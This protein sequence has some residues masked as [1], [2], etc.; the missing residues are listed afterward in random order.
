MT[1]EVTT[2]ALTISGS[3]LVLVTGQLIVRFVIDPIHDQKRHLGEIANAL[4]FY[5]NLYSNPPEP[6]QGREEPSPIDDD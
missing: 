3:V 6:L 4:I 5:A 2:A 1:P